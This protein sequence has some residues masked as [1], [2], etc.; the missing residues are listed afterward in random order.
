MLGSL[1]GAGLVKALQENPFDELNGGT[2]FVNPAFSIPTGLAA[3]IVGTFVLVYV[4][5]TA[6]DAKRRARDSHVPV[7]VPLPIGLAVFVVHLAT[8]PITGTGI[9][10]ARS[11]GPA[12]LW[13]HKLAWD[14][15]WIFWVGPFIGATLA[16][17]YNQYVI[18]CLPLGSYFLLPTFPTFPII[19]NVN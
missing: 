10:P 5:Y 4:V 11:F 14:D 9:N 18:R 17:F 8:I 1:S 3:E 2:N 13:G 19:S 15:Q 16:A 6:T 12:A 7:L